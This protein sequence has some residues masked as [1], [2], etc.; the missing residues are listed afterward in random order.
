M[1]VFAGPEISASGLVMCI[2]AANT[3]SYSGFGSTWFDLSGAGNH[4][5]LV[6]SPTAVANAIQF[7]GT[8]QYGNNTL[9]LSSGASTVIAG[10]R[11]SGAIRGRVITSRSNN[12]VLGHYGTTTSAYYAEGWVTS[13]GANDTNWR[14]YAGTADTVGDLYSFY[15]NAQ[16]VASNA[17]GAQGVNGISIGGYGPGGLGEPSSCE[18]SFVLAYNRVLSADEIRTIYNAYRGRFGI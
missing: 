16:L 13:G 10:S 8:T 6:A 7:N 14:I 3:K 18:V 17:L 11:Y 2:D 4:V 12:W 15:S 9:N 1:S 5:T